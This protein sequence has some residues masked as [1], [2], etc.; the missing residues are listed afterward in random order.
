MKDH[1]NWATLQSLGLCQRSLLR[2]FKFFK[3]GKAVLEASEKELQQVPKLN[4]KVIEKI[5]NSKRVL[6]PEKI[7]EELEKKEIQLV[8]LGDTDYPS[9]LAEIADPPVILYFKG[10]LPETQMPL[11]AIVGSRK[12]SPYGKAVAKKLAKEL[13]Q[14]G[15][16]IVSGM[17]R[18]ID[19]EAH[20]GALE[21]KGYTLAVLGCGVDIIYPREN[22]KLM[23]MIQMNGCVVSEFPLGTKPEPKN[24]PIRN[25]IISGCSLGTLV[26]EAEERSGALITAVL[27]LEQGRD[28]FAVPGSIASP[29]SRG[30]H[31]LI[32]QG[33]K[34][35]ENVE[36]IISEFFYMDHMGRR[37][38]AFEYKK[39]NILAQKKDL[40]L[41]TEEINILKLLSFEPVHVDYLIEKTGLPVS[42]ICSILTMLEV[43]GFAQ[44]LPG[45]Y[46]VSAELV[47]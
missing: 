35:V 18:G 39:E 24:F 34:L 21:N 17:A 37:I 33:A 23:Q 12:A 29:L 2:L 8:M 13:V 38:T 47:I 31:S 30:P 10:I 32:K 41:G 36:D 11:L 20:A 42:T 5:V 9:R 28:V 27:A 40:D 45:N 15:W 4:Q 26:V 6:S 25:R 19:T 22:D 14:R 44:R 16:G 46:Y 1:F 7:A 3:S 43:K